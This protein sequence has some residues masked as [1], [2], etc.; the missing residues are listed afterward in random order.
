MTEDQL[1]QKTDKHNIFFDFKV[2]KKMWS[3]NDLELRKLIDETDDYSIKRLAQK[4][5]E[6]REAE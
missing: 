4:E 1:S 6:Q 3:L 2:Y 5:L